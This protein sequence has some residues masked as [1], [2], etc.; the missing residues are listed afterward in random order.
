[1][2]EIPYIEVNQPIGSF[3]ITKMLANELV[4]LVNVTPRS[5]NNPEAIQREESKKRI[6]E[7]SHY[8][9]DPDATFPT[10]IIVSIYEEADI[11]KKDFIFQINTNSGRKIGEVIDGQHRLKGIKESNYA[12]R[13]ELPVILMFNLTEQEKAYVFSIINSKQTKVSSSLI[14]DL[15]AL[16]RHRSP[17][18]SAHEIARAFNNDLESPFYGRLKMLGKKQKD[19]EIAILSQGTFVKY[20]IELLSK[21]PDHDYRKSKQGIPLDSNNNL[22]LRIYFIENKDEI[23]L[24]ILLN[25]FQAL[26]DV[27]PKYWENPDNNILWKT[28]GYTA[29]MKSFNDLY[30][31]G[32]TKNDLSYDFFRQAF[33]IFKDHL[34][35]NNIELTGDVFPSNAQQQTKLKNIIVSSIRERM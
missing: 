27:F 28:T 30:E 21:D 16:S 14:Y 34:E 8:C 35:E 25:L 5:A 9:S 23:I 32:D 12:D 18:K 7:I 11:T 13:F 22:P 6:K 31:I 24:K 1:M 33:E 15:F 3:Y 4:E 29:I 17:Q 20:L 2:I 10:P 19:Q 26:K